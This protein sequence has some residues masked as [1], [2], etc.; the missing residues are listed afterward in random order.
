M[1][2]FCHAGIETG[3]DNLMKI[4]RTGQATPLDAKTY[5][6]ILD[7]FARPDHKLFW[8]I[9]WFSGE[10]AG[11]VLKMKVEQIYQDPLKR[12]PRAEILF[13]ARTRKDGKTREVPMHRT[14]DL[15]LRAYQPPATGY[16][17]P[18][19]LKE[20]KPLTVRALDSALRRALVRVGLENQG[21]SLHSPRRGFITEL[22]R[23]GYDV[24]VI[25]ALTGHSS[26]SMLSRYIDV[27]ADQ[28]RAA[29]AAL[30]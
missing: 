4:N 17:F 10:R 22:H 29:I 3:N 15:I 20:D 12:I 9:C 1:F 26:L 19:A 18:S 21:F 23:A 13:P 6:R 5:R 7:G 30:D 11:A 14:L 27:S 2:L 16:L 8:S 28:K 25:Q 24:R